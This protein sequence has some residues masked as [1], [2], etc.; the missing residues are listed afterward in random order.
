MKTRGFVVGAVAAMTCCSAWRKGRCAADDPFLWLEDPQQRGYR[1]GR[2]AEHA[3]RCRVSRPTR[4]TN[5]RGY[6]FRSVHVER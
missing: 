4:A 1:L 6:G 5:L 3:Q 2:R